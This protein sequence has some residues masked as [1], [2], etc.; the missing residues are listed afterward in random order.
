M[1]S[2][3]DR[4]EQLIDC[5]PDAVYADVYRPTQYLRGPMSVEEEI[6]FV[7]GFLAFYPKNGD[8]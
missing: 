6:G 5:I 1:T 2:N 3:E 7:E 8:K 4:L